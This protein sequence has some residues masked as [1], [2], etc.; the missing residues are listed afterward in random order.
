MLVRERTVGGKEKW[1]LGVTQIYPFPASSFVRAV[2][3]QLIYLIIT[4]WV[5]GRAGISISIQ[6]IRELSIKRHSKAESKARTQDPSPGQNS[7]CWLQETVSV[8]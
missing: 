3:C 2:S 4:S 5:A 1:S 6:Q 8:T 7:L